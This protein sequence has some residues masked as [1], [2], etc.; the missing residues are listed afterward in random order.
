MT[1]ISVGIIFTM[2]LACAC[3]SADRSDVNTKKPDK[4]DLEKVNTYLVEKDRERILA[5]IERK[6]L[7]LAES[8]SGI[9]YSIS[10]EGEGQ[11]FSEGS[12]VLFSYKSY[13]LDGTECYSSE[14]TGPRE[15]TVG[16]TEIEAGLS[17]GLKMLKPGGK[18]LFII[19]SF[20][21]YG[22][23]GDDKKI[24]PRAV[25]VYEIE[26]LTNNQNK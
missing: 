10:S 21:A 12:K 9:W 22:L 19:P 8:K 15:V 3:N 4:G 20:L 7:K 26:I 16:K 13:L 25:I 17:E 18:A 1:R 23:L 24:P 14:I 6:G 5:F 11:K 2:F